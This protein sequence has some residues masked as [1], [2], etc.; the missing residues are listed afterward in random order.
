MGQ[1][2]TKIHT[3]YKL[4]STGH[5]M[6]F[7]DVQNP[8]HRGVTLYGFPVFFFT[9][10]IASYALWILNISVVSLLKFQKV[11]DFMDYLHRIC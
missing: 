2:S 5:H 11:H 3:T 6:V 9:N 10:L 4:T 8:Y 1:S 7:S